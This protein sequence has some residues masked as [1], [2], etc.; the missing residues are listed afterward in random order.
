MRPGKNSLIA[1]ITA[2]CIFTFWLPF[3]VIKQAASDSIAGSIDELPESDAVIVFGTLVNDSNTVSPLLR[4]R[5][6]AGIRIIEKGRAKKIVVSN[7]RTASEVMA[8]Y[9]YSRNINPEIV[10]IDNEADDTPD[11]CRFE[12]KKHGSARKVILLSQGF[13]LPRLIYQCGKTGITG[14]AYPAEKNRIT[15]TERDSLMTRIYVRSIRYI[16]E[17]G[18]TWL[19]VLG[20]YR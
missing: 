18:L 3:L 14:T 5:L 6:E 2:S 10:E 9:L 12:R 7:M 11:T 16:R 19:A 1:I 8:R 13:H 4:E 17:A 15:T 20:I